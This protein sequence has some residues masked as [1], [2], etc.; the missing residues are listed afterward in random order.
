MTKEKLEQK[1][2]SLFEQVKNI[3]ILGE[4][5][6]GEPEILHE[7]EDYFRKVEFYPIIRNQVKRILEHVP[8]IFPEDWKSPESFDKL[9][10]KEKQAYVDIAKQGIKQIPGPIIQRVIELAIEYRQKYGKK[11]EENAR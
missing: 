10:E 8:N 5:L 3:E 7:I 11:T 4:R 1:T 9:N 6:S 2:E